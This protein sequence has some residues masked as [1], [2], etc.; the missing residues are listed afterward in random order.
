MNIICI[1]CFSN[2]PAYCCPGGKPFTATTIEERSRIV[3]YTVMVNNA[4]TNHRQVITEER[5][6]KFSSYHPMIY[7]CDKVLMLKLLICQGWQY[8][9]TSPSNLQSNTLWT[10]GL[11]SIILLTY[12]LARIALCLTFNRNEIWYVI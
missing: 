8:N 1:R 10:L 7:L 5:T 4:L 12:F 2:N 11:C 6:I 3:K 9:A